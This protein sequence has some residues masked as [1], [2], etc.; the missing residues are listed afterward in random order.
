[1]NLE[2]MRHA[3]RLMDE[4]NSAS[5]VAGIFKVSRAKLLNSFQRLKEGDIPRPKEEVMDVRTVDMFDGKTD[6]ER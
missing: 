2:Q 1:M 4:G 5:Y 6:N 3:R